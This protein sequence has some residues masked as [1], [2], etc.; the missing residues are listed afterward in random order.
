MN[1]NS[2]RT[3]TQGRPR[4]SVNDSDA[5]EDRKKL[6]NRLSQQA[7]RKRQN[8]YIL[9]LEQ[10]MERMGKADNDRIVTLEEE[11]RQLRRQLVSF[12]NKL[13][14]A[15]ASLHSLSVTMNKALEGSVLRGQEEES[16]SPQPQPTGDTTAPTENSSKILHTGA[17]SASEDLVP[18]EGSEKI[19]LSC[20]IDDLVYGNSQSADTSGLQ[21]TY[22]L[23]I[24]N[25][26][27]SMLRNRRILGDLVQL[28]E[29]EF[30]TS[31][32]EFASTSSGTSVAMNFDHSLFPAFHAITNHESSTS[33]NSGSLLQRLLHDPL[34]P[35]IHQTRSED[36]GTGL[37]DVW[38]YSYQMGPSAYHSALSN[39][40]LDSKMLASTNSYLSDHI[41]AIQGCLWA[42]WQ[43][44]E[45][46]QNSKV[47]LGQLNLSASLMLSM[48]HSL[49]RPLAMAWYISTKL[50]H[51]VAALTMWQMKP[52]R[53]MYARL[54]PRYRPSALQLTETYPIVI[55]WV[56][57]S[58]LRDKLILLHSA[59]PFLDEI[60]CD[61]STAYVVETDLSK[62]VASEAP[63][64]GYVKVWDLI[65]AMYE[66]DSDHTGDEVKDITLPAPSAGVLFHNKDYARLAFRTLGMD[67]GVSIY[68]V[69]PAIFAKYPEL[70]EPNCDILA[71]GTPL[72]REEQTSIPRPAALNKSAVSIYRHFADWSLN[73]ILNT[74]YLV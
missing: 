34:S 40:S 10:R 24:S 29:I 25:S 15:N 35:S 19:P 5:L 8:A 28:R 37:P 9:E 36:L 66:N 39:I 4:K 50:Y 38:S 56:P 13:E 6:R 11:N 69:D 64:L 26:A 62:L 58:V 12:V 3:P 48:F 14:R 32:Q 71:S 67:D 63:T 17:P 52:T 31:P 65:Q 60:V 44:V 53:E 59:N 23:D 47:S 51:H 43:Y 2:S 70:Y 30:S 45:L 16:L 54:H 57:F 49:N 22:T 74:Q 21:S 68:K 1:S 46:P 61:L 7:Y 27:D 73:A 33:D 18:P 42:K 72:L 55:D 41:T 20:Q